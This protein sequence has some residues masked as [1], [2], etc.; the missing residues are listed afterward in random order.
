VLPLT[1]LDH[2]LYYT[3]TDHHIDQDQ[4]LYY[5]LTDHH[6]DQSYRYMS[7]LSNFQRTGNDNNGCYF[8]GIWKVCRV[9]AN[10]VNTKK[11]TKFACVRLR[12]LARTRHSRSL[13]MHNLAVTLLGGNLPVLCTIGVK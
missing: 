6:I 11:I 5:T 3:L 9:Y 13:V 10:A 1:D 7:Q 8:Y 4:N 12:T 2:N